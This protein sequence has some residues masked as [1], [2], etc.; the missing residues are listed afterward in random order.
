MSLACYFDCDGTLVTYDVPYAD[1]FATAC[2]GAGVD[3]DP[4]ALR[5]VYSDAFFAAFESFHPD[6][7]REGAAAA[8][9]ARDVAADPAAFAETLR[10]VEVTESVVRAG[11]RETL[12]AVADAAALGV[13]T[14]G[15]AAQQR[16]KLAHHDLLDRFDAYVPSYDVGAHKPDAAMFE[17]ARERLPAE[18][19]CY[20]GD[21]LDHDVVP[22]REAGFLAVHVDG[23]ADRE[24]DATVGSVA[25]LGRLAELF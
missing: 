20:V 14:N 23:D 11:T 12:D 13:L 6:P 9:E 5:D 2:D 16:R 15:L 3:A 1:L 18:T 24:A 19:H 21:S 25:G 4:T 7:Y 10:R 22:A 8:F 17:A